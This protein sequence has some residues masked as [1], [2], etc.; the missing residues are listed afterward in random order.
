MSAV[1]NP[2]TGRLGI[3]IRGMVAS[4]LPNHAGRSLASGPFFWWQQVDK[5][6]GFFGSYPDGLSS[7]RRRKSLYKI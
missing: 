7:N 1:M 5:N 6:G 4:S 3:A 2:S